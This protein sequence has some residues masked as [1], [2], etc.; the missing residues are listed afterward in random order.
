MVFSDKK[1]V[2]DVITTI[3]LILISITAIAIIAA[4]VIPWVKNS[5]DKGGSC[6]ESLESMAIVIDDSCYTETETRVKIKFGNQEVDELY[7]VLGNENEDFKSYTIKK[8]V[9]D[10]MINNGRELELPDVGGGERMYIFDV[11]KTNVEI[12]AIINDEQCGIS[13]SMELKKCNE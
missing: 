9:A 4:F 13:D 1:G 10:A 7:I 2:S 12:G 6:L 5:L 8:G 11:K 3:L